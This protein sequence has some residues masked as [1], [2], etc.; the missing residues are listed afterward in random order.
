MMGSISLSKYLRRKTGIII[1]LSLL[2]VLVTLVSCGMGQEEPSM[3]QELYQSPV[4]EDTRT[5]TLMPFMPAYLFAT[6]EVYP[7]FPD[8]PIPSPTLLPDSPD[9]ENTIDTSPVRRI[10]VPDLDLDALV[11]FAPFEGLTWPVDGLREDVGWL[12]DTSWPG[13]GGN[14]V[15]AGHVTVKGLGDGPFRY[16][17]ELN[18]GAEVLVYTEENVYTYAVKE[19]LTV[20][21][22][23][24]GVTLPT[25]N[26]QLTL[27][28]CTGWDT[29]LSIYR[30]RRVVV[31]EL[32][33]SEVIVRQGAAGD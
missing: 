18:E 14:T 33:S 22:T 32:V 8:Y 20:N 9:G 17:E 10:V 16:L 28:T 5:P 3:T 11:H 21:E 12:G 13:L 30:F 27:I 6:P 15:L 29:D 23:D 2:M 31:A 25:T 1:F 4:P 19:Q 26:P 7:E 24:L